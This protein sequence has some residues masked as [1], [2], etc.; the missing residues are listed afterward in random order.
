MVENL[1]ENE[2]GLGF[3]EKVRLR[4]VGEVEERKAIRTKR[5]Q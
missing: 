1:E 3:S 4:G 2:K 5:S